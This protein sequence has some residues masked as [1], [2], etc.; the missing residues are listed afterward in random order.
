[1]ALNIKNPEVEQLAADVARLAGET[2]TEAVKRAL[3]ERKARLAHR[4]D[5][6]DRLG[7]VTRFLERDVWPVVPAG[8][9]GRRMSRQEEDALLGFG[10][11]G[12]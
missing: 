7:R 10:P 6:A 8:E 3:A 11:D 4:V 1:M 12:V 9:A 2:K 5:P